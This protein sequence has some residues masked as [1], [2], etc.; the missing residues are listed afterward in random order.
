MTAITVG[1]EV[2]VCLIA[3]LAV[4]FIA[5]NIIEWIIENIT[6]IK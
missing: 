1:I 6:N 5:Y 2:I 3:I 4:V